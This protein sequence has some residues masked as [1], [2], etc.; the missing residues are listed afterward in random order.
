M[1]HDWGDV[2]ITRLEANARENLRQYVEA[3]VPV[4]P[5]LGAGC[6]AVA[7]GTAAWCGYDSPLNSVKGAGPDLTDDSLDELEAF[8]GA[9]GG[10][11]AIIEAA[12]WV[13]AST[14]K[15]LAGRGYQAG[16]VE[17]VMIR[18]VPA[19][20]GRPAHTVELVPAAEWPE[21][22]WQAFEL[23]ETLAWRGLCTAAAHMPGAMHLG[24]RDEAGAWIACA[25][26]VLAGDVWIFG[27]DGTLPSARGQGAQ[28]ALIEAR[29]QRIPP[30]A[31]VCA[32]VA[33]GGGSQ[34]NY[35]RAGFRLAYTRTALVRT[36][37]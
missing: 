36:L 34:R 30:G 8:F 10:P 17:D 18:E 5:R 14:R 33:P 12:P 24:V 31:L 23:P 27:C 7:G 2:M 9:R 37:G 28:R 6:I 19:T 4:A 11:H 20:T 26:A 35:F 13:E 21:L 16:S 22:M 32:E 1:S 29:V 25:M 15:R 3:L